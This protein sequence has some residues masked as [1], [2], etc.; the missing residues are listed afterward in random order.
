L[1]DENSEWNYNVN[2]LK[3][4]LKARHLDLEL[5]RPV[6]DEVENVATFYL[7][8]L[9]GQMVGYQQYRPDGEKKPQ[10]NPKEG[11][12]F[13]Y[14]K[15]PTLGLWGVESL[16]LSDNVVFLCEGV[17]DACRM[18]KRGY[19]ALAVLSNNTGHDLSNWLLCLNRKVVAVCDNDS[20]GKKLAKFGDCCVFTTEK[21]L[22]DSSEEYVTHLLE[23]FS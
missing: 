9:S 10:N 21:D 8:N 14:R 13:T 12:Y 19:S 22:G 23:T 18:T 20:A 17:F 7:W 3:N 1:V 6:L 2:M 11:K 16:H 5:H 15:Q 4:H